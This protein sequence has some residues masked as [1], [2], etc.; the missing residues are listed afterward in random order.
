VSDTSPADLAVAFRSFPRRLR[1]GLAALDDDAARRA[2]EP[3]AAAARAGIVEAARLLG[4]PAGEPDAAAA[5]VAD[6]IAA[7]H[8][9]K[10]DDA[11]LAG[12]RRHALA[13]GA[14]LRAIDDLA[15]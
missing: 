8:P 2:A 15:H 10:W 11:T 12:L 6:R 7:V 9:D 14:A 13:V 5:A 4:A 1:Q 3:H